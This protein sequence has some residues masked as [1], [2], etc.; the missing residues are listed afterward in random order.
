M[1]AGSGLRLAHTAVLVAVCVVV[2]GTGHALASG[3]SLPAAA[4][5]IAVPPVCLLAWRLTRKERSAGV[6]VSVGAAVQAFLHLLFGAVPHGSGSGGA[7]HGAGHTAPYGTAGELPLPVP[8]S[9]SGPPSGLPP[10]GASATASA[11]S[12]I[13]SVYEFASGF[14]SGFVSG[15][16]AAFTSGPTASMTAAHL[17][18]GAVCGWWFWHGQR[19]LAR[20]ALALH[21][22][23]RGRLRLARAVLHG[24]YAVLP[25]E[26]VRPPRPRPQRVRLPAS[27]LLLRAVTRRGPPLLPS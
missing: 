22:F 6:V 18:A 9:T 1:R 10:D 8:G 2:S 25:P 20:I 3:T 7:H 4:Y 19:A 16:T 12:A 5:G 11:L 27:L 24:A 21:L 13:S 23:L 17:A 26:S 15:L 14:A